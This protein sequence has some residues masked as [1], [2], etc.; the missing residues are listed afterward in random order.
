[1]T[2]IATVTPAG[3]VF[4]VAPGVATLTAIIGG[5]SG[6]AVVTVISP[7][8]STVVVTL[9]SASMTAGTTQQATAVLRDANNQVVTGRTVAWTSSAPAIA[10]VDGA[11][12]VITAV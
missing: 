9:P 5:V 7:T 12:G 10:Q 6:S 2:S 11:T 3:A 4:G 1:N 8:V